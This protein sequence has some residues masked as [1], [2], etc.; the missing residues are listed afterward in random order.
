MQFEYLGCP[1]CCN[2]KDPSEPGLDDPL[3]L[4]DAA[5]FLDIP[6]KLGRPYLLFIY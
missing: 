5:C 3:H 6:P 4:L 1:D 2:A